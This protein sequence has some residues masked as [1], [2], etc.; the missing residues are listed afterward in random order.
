MGMY[1]SI[2][3]LYLTSFQDNTFGPTVR[4]RD[5]MSPSINTT[6]FNVLFIS[7]LCFLFV[8]LVS[9]ILWLIAYKVKKRKESEWDEF[10]DEV[11]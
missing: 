1:V 9:F 3:I 11:F 2:F 4:I 7:V 5:T 10:D 8:A 6:D